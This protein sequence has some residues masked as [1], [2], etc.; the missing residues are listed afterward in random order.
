MFF[1]MVSLPLT[2]IVSTERRCCWRLLLSLGGVSIDLPFFMVMVFC[3]G[4]H[5]FWLIIF[6][7]HANRKKMLL[8]IRWWGQLPIDPRLYVA[9]TIIV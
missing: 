7:F 3:L 6:V 1:K 5:G 4:F 8:V 2:L 9:T